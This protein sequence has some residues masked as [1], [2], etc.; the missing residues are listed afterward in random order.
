MKIFTLF[1]MAFAFA[2]CNSA[3][4]DSRM[5]KSPFVND[6]GSAVTTVS[7]AVV[8]KKS[9]EYIIHTNGKIRSAKEQ[10]ILAENG[11]R[12]RIF[13]VSAGK[14]FIQGELM[15]QLDITSIEYQ[16][17]RAQQARFNTEKEYESQLL[18]YEQLLQG[19]TTGQ[20]DTIRRKLKIS[21]GLSAAEQD[22]REANYAMDRAVFTAPFAGV[23]A[24]IKVQQGDQLKPGQ[25]LFRLY[26]PYQLLME[27]KVLEADISLISIGT[28]AEVVP[29]SNPQR[30]YTA[31]VSEINPYVDENGLVLVKLKVNSP[32]TINGSSALF[33][34]M[35]C[36]ATIILP[37]ANTL[38]VPKEAI[39]MRNGKAVVFTLDNGKA[40]WHYV[41]TGRDNGSA[42]EILEGLETG[43]KVIT[44]NN[45][46]LMH[47]APVTGHTQSN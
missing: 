14:K 47:D 11:G 4:G 23:I 29:V 35:N 5:D 17:E 45:L 42:V 44:S 13:N 43:Q 24:D 34:G 10:V 30:K 28:K 18:G 41:S 12:L 3:S 25:E 6:P 9:F 40:K 33:P 1:S 31:S 22:I 19:K 37:F 32:G 21:T 2:S 20:G 16:L 46:Q 27:T 8:E 15:A 39:V 38:I 26:D 7:T 36:M